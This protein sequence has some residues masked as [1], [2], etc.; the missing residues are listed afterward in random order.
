MTTTP[1]P[2][3]DKSDDEDGTA[4]KNPKKK[5]TKG[6]KKKEKAKKKQAADGDLQLIPEAIPVPSGNDGI[7][8]PED[9]NPKGDLKIYGKS[10]SGSDNLKPL[11]AEMLKL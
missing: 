3:E 8:L 1:C 4:M 5:L 6:Q 10:E 9:F 7:V 11:A 2:S